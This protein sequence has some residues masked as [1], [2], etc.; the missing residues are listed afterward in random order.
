MAPR[1]FLCFL[2]WDYV[3]S[4]PLVSVFLLSFLTDET[5][6][7]APSGRSLLS[8]SMVFGSFFPDPLNDPFPPRDLMFLRGG[9]EMNARRLARRLREDH[10]LFL[11]P[12]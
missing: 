10:P 6:C 5:T 4:L 12:F 7:E 11:F 8:E 3:F 9:D 1:R 2:D